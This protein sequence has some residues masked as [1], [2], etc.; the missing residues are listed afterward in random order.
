MPICLLLYQK[1]SFLVGVLQVNLN[2]TFNE[3]RDSSFDNQ[4]KISS[5]KR[6]EVVL[7]SLSFGSINST[8]DGR[9]RRSL[10]LDFSDD[11]EASDDG[12]VS[13]NSFYSSP[14]SLGP[15]IENFRE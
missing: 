9:D 2:K 8:N 5:N 14:K 12:A 15:P 4:K 11:E 13:S 3:E 10:S 1:D 7:K 6:K